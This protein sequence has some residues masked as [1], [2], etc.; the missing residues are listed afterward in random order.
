VKTKK[1]E[2][3][4]NST[5]ACNDAHTFI[6]RVWRENDEDHSNREPLWRGLISHV[7]SSRQRYFLDVSEVA[8]FIQEYTSIQIQIRIPWWQVLINRIRHNER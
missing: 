5:V 8:R 6:V 1:A 3:S 4:S 2:P 7:G